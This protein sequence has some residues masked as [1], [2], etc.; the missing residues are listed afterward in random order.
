MY[1]NEEKYSSKVIKLNK[2]KNIKKKLSSYSKL[3]LNNIRYIFARTENLVFDYLNKY[4]NNIINS[5]GFT[6]DNY[7]EETA[8][9]FNDSISIDEGCNFNLLELMGNNNF[10]TTQENQHEI[11]NENQSVLNNNTSDKKKFLL[12]LLE[13][14]KNYNVNFKCE[15]IK[16]LLR[17]LR[18]L[19]FLC[20]NP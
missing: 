6:Y 12:K 4:D 14:I 15:D 18:L 9:Y 19:I 13:S 20:E 10:F 3:D 1:K 5:L 16:F 2:S 7:L 8:F 11:Q 17:K